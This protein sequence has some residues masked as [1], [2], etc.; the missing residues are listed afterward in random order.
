[1]IQSERLAGYAVFDDYRP[2][3]TITVIVRW[4]LLA[5][6]ISMN[7]YRVDIGSSWLTIN[8]MAFALAGLNAYM[9]WRIL[10]Q[11]R[12]T[13]VHAL[14]ISTADL[15]VVTASLYLHLGF[16]NDFYAFYYP[17][18][19]GFSLMF[20]GRPSFVMVSIVV[21]LFIL[22]AFTVTPTLDVDFK[23]EKVLIVRIAAMVGVTIGGSLINGWERNRRREAVG[24]ERAIAKENL[25]LERRAKRAELEATEERNRIAREIHDGVAQSIYMLSLQ[26]ETCADLARENSKGLTER[27]TNLVSLSKKTLLEVRYYIFDLKPYLEGQKGMVSMVENQVRESTK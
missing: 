7:N 23:Q 14:I 21:G 12:L 26:L 3:L 6:F 15:V 10:Q 22:M 9:T 1:M 11:R 2:T 19:L 24:A 5:V 4:L 25:Q 27:L 16:Q 17:P 18:L 13:W 8:F 20:P